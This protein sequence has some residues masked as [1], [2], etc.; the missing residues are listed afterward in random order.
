MSSFH[1]AITAVVWWPSQGARE[2]G[3]SAP[4]PGKTRERKGRARLRKGRG[5]QQ[6]HEL[7]AWGRPGKANQRRICSA[8]TRKSGWRGSPSPPRP[9]PLLGASGEVPAPRRSDWCELPII[10]RSPAGGRRLLAYIL[11]WTAGGGAPKVTSRR[12]P[13]R[14][15]NAASYLCLPTP[16]PTTPPYQH[17]KWGNGGWE[18]RP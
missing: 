10:C 6:N 11:A 2:L 9:A 3:R 15:L 1:G 13:S 18:V 17:G 7:L 16:T 12:W 8:G 4:S 14:K 5:L